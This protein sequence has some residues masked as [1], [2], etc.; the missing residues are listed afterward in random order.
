M[1][2]AFLLFLFLI[3]VTAFSQWTWLNPIPEGNE[4]FDGWFSST[5]KGWV[6]GGN[7][8]VLHTT[9]GGASWLAQNTPL[10]VTPFINLSIVSTDDNNGMIAANNSSI[11]RTKDGGML[12]ELLPFSSLGI[13]RLKRAPD[14]SIWG[15]GSNGTIARTTDL[16]TTWS[17]FNTGVATVVFDVDFVSA[18]MVHVSCGGGRILTSADGGATWTSKTLL[19]PSDVVA[20]DFISATHGFAV[21]RP[22]L[23]L[24]TT[25]GGQT[26]SDSTVFITTFRTV[27]FAD[28]QTGWL[29]SAVK[30]TVLKTTNGGTSWFEVEVDPTRRYSFQNIVTQGGQWALV[31]GEGG[32]L[33]LTTNG[34]SSW[35]QLGSAVTRAHLYGIT[36]LNDSTAFTFGENKILST[37]NRGVTWTQVNP[38][39]GFDLHTG[40]A[41]SSSRLIGGGTQGHVALSTDGGLSWTTVATL[42]A[43]GQI[44][45]IIFLNE[46]DGWLAGNHGTVARTSDGG[47]T[48]VPAGPPSTDDFNGVSA[49]TSLEAWI[50]GNGGKVF[51]TSDGGTTWTPQPT[52]T[53][54]NLHGVHFLNTQIGWIGGQ[55][56]LLKTTD[57]GGTWSNATLPGLDVVYR[58]RFTDAQTGFFMVSRGVARTKDGGA[59]FYRMD[60]PATGLNELSVLPGG[61]LWLAGDF[62]VLQRYTPTAAVLVNP[63]TLNFGSVAVGRTKDMSFTIDNTGELPMDISNVI[64]LGA[65]FSVVSLGKT[66]LNPGEFTTA[67]IRFAPVDTGL[68]RG[69]ATVYSNA[70][71]GFPTVDLVA[72]GVPLG[73]PALTHTPAVVDFGKIK[74]GTFKSLEVHLQNQSTTNLLI[75]SYRIAGGDSIMFQIAREGQYFLSPGMNDSVRVLFGPLR[76]GVFTSELIIHSNDPLW[77][78]Y[79]IPLRGEAVNPSIKLDTTVVDFGYVYIDSTKT[80]FIRISNVGT[81]TLVTTNY[82]LFEVDAAEFLVIPPPPQTMIPPNGSILIPLSFKPKTYGPK[83]AKLSFESNDIQQPGL[84]LE[85]KG[86]ATTL[87][88][89]RL[90]AVPSH[91]SL[92]PVYPNPASLRENGQVKVRFEMVH[93]ATIHLRVLDVLGRLV[94][95]VA[96]GAYEPGV[97]DASFSISGMQPGVYFIEFQSASERNGKSVRRSFVIVK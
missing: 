21:Q 40:Y 74:L 97:Y 69:T 49:V 42:L 37:T 35:Q 47:T 8:S 38:P 26:W 68:V 45:Q 6:V 72:R 22:D 60:Y 83:F 76:P 77:P 80:L 28:T 58:I 81:D 4:Y 44:N 64:S 13:Q 87:S 15:F 29:L 3:P 9:D 19:L 18:S 90:D 78:Q 54:A 43:A 2:R 31:V 67:T 11:L 32:G 17:A 36:G 63:A 55:L 20:I 82:R 5:S 79:T 94:H 62:G 73:N 14:G 70:T 65:G 66:R 27:R 56:V 57:G 30:G 96:D 93:H 71:L 84:L 25:D 91:V 89:D 12:W 23:L 85:L 92:S 34:G 33:F 39:S 50:V 86:N 1:K 88:T 59:T 52:N 95:T 51:H 61:H 53:S 10:K 41:L 16:G 48:W 46:R 75:S 24:R 7:G